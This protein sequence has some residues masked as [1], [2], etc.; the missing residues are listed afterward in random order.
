MKCL[1]FV[2]KRQCAYCAIRNETFKVMQ[3]LKAVLGLRHLVDVCR[4][5]GEG[6]VHIHFWWINHPGTSFSPRTSGFPCQHH[7]TY[8]CSILTLS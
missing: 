3:S 8:K 5:G 7:S 1:A 2:L 6:S 4:R